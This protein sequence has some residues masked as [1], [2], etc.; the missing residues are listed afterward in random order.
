MAKL[1]KPDYVSII[2]VHYSQRDEWSPKTDARKVY[3]RQCIDS[4]EKN[5]DYPAEVIVVDNGGEEDNSNYILDKVRSGT[6]NTYIRNKDNMF[7]GWGWNQGVKLATSDFIVLLTNDIAFEKNWLTKSLH[8]LLNFEEKLVVG[9]T[10]GK[11]KYDEPLRGGYI[12]NRYAGSDCMLLTKDIFYEVGE[13]ATHHLAGGIWF[14][15]LHAA[16]YSVATAEKPLART[17]QGWYN[18]RFARHR[19]IEVKEHLLGGSIADFTDPY[20]VSNLRR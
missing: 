2:V 14:R 19:T 20:K 8:P 13:Y 9:I 1:S 10:P 7:Y 5:T 16:G 6:I 12:L 15:K 4:I 18:T 17:I 11:E 3:F